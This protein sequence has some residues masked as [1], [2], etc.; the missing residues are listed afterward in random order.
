MGLGRKGK[1]I[2]MK[3]EGRERKG[4]E[5]ILY[6]DKEERNGCTYM[7]GREVRWEGRGAPVDVIDLYN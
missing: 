1:G 7:R 3:R 4:K 5:G 2:G 6:M